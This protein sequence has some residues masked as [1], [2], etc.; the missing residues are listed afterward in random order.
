MTRTRLRVPSA[1]ELM[2]PP[3][4]SAVRLREVGNAFAHA[5]TIA[6]DSGAGTLVHVGRFDLS[7]F[8][9]VLEP[10][11]KL[12]TA[13][14][15]LYAA[16][17]AMADALA[18]LAEPETSI[19]FGWPD[20]VTVNLGLVGGGQLA[21]PAGTAEDE[22]P[23]WLVFGGMIRAALASDLEPGA[24]P[25]KTSLEEEGFG[26]VASNQLIEAFARHFMVAID[27]WQESGFA[28]VAK[29]YL[30]RLPPEKGARRDIDE[31]GDLLTTRMAKGAPERRSLVA[32]CAAPAWFDPATR[33]PLA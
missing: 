22:V 27:S 17:V 24:N 5:Q 20:A 26:N 23:A 7:E 30:A 11:E 2:L 32:A 19:E 4:F 31:N 12:R 13:R 16:M 21:W 15:T 8:A 25:T 1:Q 14:R 6:A 10:D 28:A 29:S 9:L 33:G 18:A 3:L